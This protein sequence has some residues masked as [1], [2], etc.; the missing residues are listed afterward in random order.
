MEPCE[1][2]HQPGKPYTIH[3]IDAAERRE[4]HHLRY[5]CPGH[6]EAYVLLAERWGGVLLSIEPAF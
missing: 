5:L 2:C 3:F 6:A 1:H 4:R